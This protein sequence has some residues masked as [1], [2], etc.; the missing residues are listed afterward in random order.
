MLP[1]CTTRIHRHGRGQQMKLRL[2][3]PMGA[4]AAVSMAA[5]TSSGSS[6]PKGSDSASGSSSSHASGHANVNVRIGGDWNTL[7][8][9]QTSG[10][11]NTDILDSGVFDRLVALGPDGKTV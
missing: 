9:Y 2:L 5:C 3:V 10:N 1:W 7:D 6:S 8:P 4:M 11:L